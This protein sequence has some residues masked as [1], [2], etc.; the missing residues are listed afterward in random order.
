MAYIHY[1]GPRRVSRARELRRTQT[2]AEEILWAS[3]RNRQLGGYKIR[4]QE[5]LNEIIVDFYCTEKRLSIEIDGPYHGS[6]DK[7][8]SDKIRDQE[9]FEHGFEILRFTNDQ[10]LHNLGWVLETILTTLNR[11]P[12]TGKP[13]LNHSPNPFKKTP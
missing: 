8:A 4:R 7:Q 12:S 13:P 5:F 1:E 6:P 3:V 10:V 11:L 9:L 2:E